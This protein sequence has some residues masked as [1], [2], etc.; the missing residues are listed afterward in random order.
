MLASYNQVSQHQSQAIPDTDNN[1]QKEAQAKPN[2]AS[3]VNISFEANLMRE[4]AADVMQGHDLTNISQHDLDNLTDNLYQSNVLT[5]Q[6]YA[7]L[8]F[9]GEQVF[10]SEA[11]ND[12]YLQIDKNQPQNMI[13]K[14]QEKLDQLR[15]MRA[16]PIAI[17][18][19]VRMVNVLQNLQANAG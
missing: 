16:K 14:W 6:E 3:V 19:A 15:E 2:T 4:H 12:T 18:Q 9:F 17:Q 13:E 1:K 8:S 7:S 5:S 11:A 10:N